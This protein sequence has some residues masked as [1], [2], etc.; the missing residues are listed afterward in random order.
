[1]KKIISIF[2]CTAIILS[3]LAMP[4]ITFAATDTSTAGQVKTQS[5]A[6]NVRKSASTS[7][8]VLTT[9]KN[10]SWVTIISTS[11]NFY[12]VEYAAG[13]YGYCHKDYI[14][15]SSSSYARYVNISSGNLNVRKGAGT[16]YDIVSTLSKGANVVVISVSGSWSKILYSGTKTGYVMSSYLAQKNSTATYSKTTLS[17]VS[18]SQTDSRWSAVKIG[19]SGDTIGSSGCTTTCL[20]MTESYRTGTTVTPAQMAAK[21]SYSSTGMLYWPS[22]YNT[23]LVSSSDYLSV[24]YSALKQGKPVV[25]GSKKSN[26][27]QHWVVVTGHTVQST[28]LNAA[29]FSIN[30]PGSKTRKTLADFI[31]A[32]PVLYKTAIYK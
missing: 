21:L 11:G 2:I 18:F 22:N 20:A 8:E 27:S 13:K 23:Q 24:I 7:S 10:K 15:K 3:C 31:S 19:T 29:D 5:T 26:G 14:T 25:L 32:Y 16:S 9:L 1:M 12:K 6:L 28:T 30:D 4:N 17:V